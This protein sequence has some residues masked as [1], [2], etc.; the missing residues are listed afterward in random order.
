VILDRILTYLVH[1]HYNSKTI[2]TLLMKSNHAPTEDISGSSNFGVYGS[3]GSSGSQETSGD[4]AGEVSEAEGDAA[5]TL[6]SR[7]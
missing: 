7:S 5:I 2:K 6:F 1:Q 4:V 3:S